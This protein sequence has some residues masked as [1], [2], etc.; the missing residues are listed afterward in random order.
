LVPAS[1]S[2]PL[3]VL[4]VD[5]A[6]ALCESLSRLFKMDGLAVTAA[7]GGE[8][9]VREAPCA[10]TRWST[11]QKLQTPGT[12]MEPA[13]NFSTSFLVFSLCGSLSSSMPLLISGYS[14]SALFADF[15]ARDSLRSMWK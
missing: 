13:I 6:T 1:M 4:L 2:E 10:A 9:G 3:A 7:H 15:L 8:S 14:F 12:H 5:D 11:S